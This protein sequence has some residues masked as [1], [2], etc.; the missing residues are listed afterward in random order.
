MS[1]DVPNSIIHYLYT[2]SPYARRIIW[3][4][5][6]RNI[7]HAQCLQP[8]TMPRPD[9]TALGVQYR[10]IP[11]LSIGRDIYLDTRLILRVLEERFPATSSSPF[12][13]LAPATT[14]DQRTLQH[15]FERFTVDAGIFAR[16]AQCIPPNTPLLHDPKFQKDRESL[17]GNSW[18]PADYARGRPE[19]L[20][21]MRQA[22]GLLEE[23]LGDGRDWILGTATPSLGDIEAVWPFD[24]LAQMEGALPA[25][26]I[27]ARQFP[28][29]FAWMDRFRKTV[30][31][32]AKSNA[33][34]AGKEVKG[35]EALKHVEGSGF[36]EA[37]M[38][39]DED[40]PTGL[41]A[42]TEVQIWPTD[43]GSSHKDR[44]KLVGLTKEEV[45]IAARTKE[46][47]EEVRIHAPRWGFRIR[48]VGEGVKL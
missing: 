30:K 9:L 43:Y 15:L 32:A 6:L 5:T 45:V 26:T 4:L 3:Y 40:D 46:R 18:D 17:F 27:S 22:F 14:A 41:K 42:G 10:R 23:A 37:E 28:R 47:G 7:P 11:I 31:E 2:F 35:E 36:V 20:A 38:R 24:W 29:T 13:A 44:G 25:A 33:Q 39:V 21:G 12:R 34:G 48:Q 19:A 1:S 16:A 8:V